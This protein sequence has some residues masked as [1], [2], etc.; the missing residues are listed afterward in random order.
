MS[1]LKGRIA[2]IT[3]SGQGIGRQIALE[4]TKRGATVI[5]NDVS[6]C[7]AEDV[8]AEIRA[9]GGD[10]MAFTS[11]VSSAEEVEAMFKAV[12]DS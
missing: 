4:L 11:D 7:C 6:G 1:D 12:L 2:L 5:T 10:G 9:L 3:G 8:L